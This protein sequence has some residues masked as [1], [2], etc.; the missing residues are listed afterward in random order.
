MNSRKGRFFAEML[1]TGSCRTC[2]ANTQ[3]D[4]RMVH[5]VI[6][7]EKAAM[8]NLFMKR[9]IFRCFRIYSLCFLRSGN[10]FGSPLE[11]SLECSVPEIES[12]AFAGG[13]ADGAGAEVVCSDWGTVDGSAESAGCRLAG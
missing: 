4:D 8:R 7:T 9:F 10:A 1:M 2:V 3:G 11:Y 13:A 12:S 5:N 6:I